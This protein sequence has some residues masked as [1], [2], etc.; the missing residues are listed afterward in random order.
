MTFLSDATSSALM[1]TLSSV[2][3]SLSLVFSLSEV[4]SF[5][6]SL[7]EPPPNRLPKKSPIALN[8]STIQSIIPPM[9]SPIPFT[10]SPRNS[11]NPLS[12]SLRS[13]RW[14]I[15]SP[16]SHPIAP[17]TRVPITLPITVPKGPPIAVPR[18][19][20]STSPSLAPIVAPPIFPPIKPPTALRRSG[21]RSTIISPRCSP[22]VLNTLFIRPPRL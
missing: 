1:T 14:V 10:I 6:L 18:T 9:R 19:P 13:P 5:S 2:V 3:L 8:P 7:E 20:P 22:I 4:V 11:K 21:I 15:S 16:I 17:P 12:T